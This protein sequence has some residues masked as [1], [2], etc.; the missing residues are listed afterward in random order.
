MPKWR[1]GRRGRLKIGWGNP[2]GFDSHLRHHKN[3]DEEEILLFFK[4]AANIIN[5]CPDRYSDHIKD[6]IL[7][8]DVP[9]NIIPKP[10]LTKLASLKDA[11]VI[12][13][14]EKNLEEVISR[15]KGW[16]LNTFRESYNY[17]I[18]NGISLF[19]K[20]LLNKKL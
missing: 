8:K 12:V 2:C 9:K 11:N 18:K 13:I 17:K 7:N 15:M 10:D 4:L 6:I 19:K 1:N 5:N 3:Y 20:N 16:Q 14:T